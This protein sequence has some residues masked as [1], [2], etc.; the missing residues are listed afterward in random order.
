MKNTKLTNLGF[1]KISQTTEG[2]VPVIQ[3]LTPPSNVSLPNN[4]SKLWQDNFLIGSLNKKTLYRIK[5]DKNFN[6]VIYYEEIFIGDRIRDIVY[7]ENQNVILLS[8]ELS[9]SI[10]I[11][12]NN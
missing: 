4:F 7:L 10:G 2:E 3:P 12:K 5:F 8:L 6:R 9:G 1:I 11:I